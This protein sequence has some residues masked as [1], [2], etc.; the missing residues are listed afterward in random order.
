MEDNKMTKT[1]K[2]TVKETFEVDVEA[3]AAQ[4]GV[5]IKDV[6]VDVQTYFRDWCRQQVEMLGLTPGNTNGLNP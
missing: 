3:W 4:F 6:K 2:V 1:V 5:D